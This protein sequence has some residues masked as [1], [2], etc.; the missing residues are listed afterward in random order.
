M[1][2]MNTV[3]TPVSEE[4]PKKKTPLIVSV[5]DWL[6]VICFAAVLVVLRCR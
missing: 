4:K 1:D 6:E 3:N 2:E 5:Y